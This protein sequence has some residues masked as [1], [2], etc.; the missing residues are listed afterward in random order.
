M[1]FQEYLETC[2]S[3]TCIMSVEKKPDGGYGDIRIVTGNQAYIDSIERNEDD[4]SDIAKEKVFVPNS[5]YTKYF[6]H[7]L[8]FEDF[9]YR[10]A[11]K[12]ECL[13]TYVRPERFNFWF[14][15]FFMPLKS[16]D[17]NIG[18]C[19]YTFTITMNADAGLMSN[20][21]PDVSS[22]VL[23][24]CIKLYSGSNFQTSIDETIAFIR[25]LCKAKRCCL[26]LT[27]FNSRTCSML[28]DDC[29]IEGDQA[30]SRNIVTDDFFEV[31]S[32]WPATIAGSDFL[33][34]KNEQDMQVLKAR[35]P[36]W[37][38]SLK[39]YDVNTL[40]LYPLNYGG[41]TKGYIWVVE[42]DV[43]NAL[44]IRETLELTTYFISYAIANYQLLNRLKI[45]STTDL[46]TG[47]KN[48]NA[49]NYRVRGLVD[50][51]EP[52]PDQLYV[53]FVD[54]NG[55]KQVNDNN[56]HLAG[57][58]LLKNAA[59][60]LQD[61]VLGHDVYRAGGDEFIVFVTGMN[62][63][64]FEKKIEKLRHYS[65]GNEDVCM[66]IGYCADE[67]RHDI[68]FDMRTADERMYAEKEAYYKRFP[69]RRHK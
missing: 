67:G 6:P 59:L 33:M 40:V 22:S 35:N 34:I 10:A 57:D 52:F 39:Q 66:A 55:L 29:I 60:I 21:A 23:Q 44:M 51:D 13:H 1:N 11:V 65:D 12:K 43:E 4:N 8:N 26:L 48:R 64:E 7:E 9:C 15:L 46:L 56:G 28:S 24:T 47:V 36:I 32:T 45:M 38:E 19:A 69:D 16:D 30:L 18:Y 68:R 31:V 25:K 63:N 58:M 53:V 62:N 49:M 14:N 54:L 5:L 3:M 20:I 50:G 17:E 37:Y 42:F 2:D 61:C 41:E 27:D